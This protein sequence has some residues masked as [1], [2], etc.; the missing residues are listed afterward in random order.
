MYV[1]CK[2]LATVVITLQVA[3]KV[4]DEGITWNRAMDELRVE[5]LIDKYQDQALL[6]IIDK[7]PNQPK[8]QGKPETIPSLEYLVRNQ[9]QVKQ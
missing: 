9:K 1:H 6:V 5:K 7:W 2:Q 4:N 8:F 3:E